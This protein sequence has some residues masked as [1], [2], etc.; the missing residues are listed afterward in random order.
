MNWKVTFSE[1]ILAELSA[2]RIGD[3]RDWADV[4]TKNYVNTIRTG[5]AQSFPSALPAP[6]LNPLAPPPFPLLQTPLQPSTKRVKAFNTIIYAYFA[7]KDLALTKEAVKQLAKDIKDIINQ[8]KTAQQEV[9]T[10]IEEI[11]LVREELKQLPE[12]I[13]EILGEIQAE[14]DFQKNEIKGYLIH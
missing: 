3:A 2:G 9:R 12:V 13:K 11:K 4:I 6:G 7:S 10:L 14:I 1:P 8:I 5:T